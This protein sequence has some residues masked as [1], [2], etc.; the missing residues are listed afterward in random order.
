MLCSSGYSNAQL[1]ID[2][3]TTQ[4][5]SISDDGYANVPLQFNFPY[6]GQ[7]F[8]NS[9]MFSNGIVSF[10]DPE[11]SGL[12]WN[13]LNVQPFTSTMGS[14]Y[15]YSI[16]ALWTDL[17]NI[18]GTFRSEGSTGFQRYSWIGISPYYDSNRLNTFSVELRPDG[19]IITT[20][21]GINA[22]YASVGMTGNT[23]AGEFEQ[24][25][26]H[27][28]TVTTGMIPNWERY[29]FDVCTVNP[30]SS[31]TCSGYAQAYYNYQCST[32]PLYDSGCPGYTEAYFSQQ[33]S[34]NPLYN[35]SCAGYAQAYFEYQCSLNPFYNAGCTGYAQALALQNL[36]QQ[37]TATVET[38]AVPIATATVTASSPTVAL[39]DPTKTETVVT[40]DV[41]GVELT[42]SGQVSVPTGQTTATRESIKEATKETPTEE[43]KKTTNT[44]ALTIAQNAV[45]ESERL[46]L[47][48]VTD[49]IAISNS[50]V[51]TSEAG[52]G[53]GSSNSGSKSSD[54]S[55]AVSD[56]QSANQNKQQGTI[57]LQ[58]T[59]PLAAQQEV[60]QKN[61]P[62]VRNGGRVDGLD[63]GPDPAQ[64]SRP[65]MDFNQYLQA[66]MQDSQ[67][68]SSKEIYRNQKPVD[69]QRLLR[70]LT[71]GTDALHRQMVDQQF[72]IGN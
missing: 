10:V 61:G 56:V 14:Q 64:F 42:L 15:N 25:A 5:H 70:G 62:S 43:K 20:Y 7:T 55:S 30:L 1:A 39:A 68:Y 36:Q 46:S 22:N 44:R 47:T 37:P 9:W 52:V 12:S 16:Y 21:S 54:S 48:V 35:Q 6:Y 32:N 49:S 58:N 26:Y 41:G 50:D 69:N 34:L 65:P 4:T 71:Q 11:V 60:Q 53:T 24:I 38:Y 31:P 40:T 2:P 33:C 72:N 57:N 66:Q 28:S 67:M 17:I 27:P 3:V 23:S 19:K 8:N 59:N 13:N 18:S 63:G 51:T 45:R 29:T